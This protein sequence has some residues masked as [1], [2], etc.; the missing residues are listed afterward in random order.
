MDFKEKTTLGRTGLK[1]GRLGISS[2]YGAPAAAFEEAFER[3]CNYFNMG[4][5]IKGRSKEMMKAIRNITAKG[6]RDELV[7]A[8]YDYTHSPLIGHRH[9]MKGLRKMG[10]A[11]VDELLLGYYSSLPRKSVMDWA[12]RLKKQGLARH[13][14]VSS[15]NRKAFAAF[16]REGVIDIY[17]VRYNAVN[18]GAEK[19]VFPQ[20]PGE[21]TPGIVAYTATRWGQLLKEKKMPPGEK[22]LTASDCYRFVLSHPAVDI[23][24]TGARNLDMLRE[25]LETLEMG[26]LTADEMSRIRRIGDFIYGKKRD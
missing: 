11:Y 20:L 21:N 26:P 13:I 14:G 22:P 12:V 3:G 8:M 16:S 7:V 5:F 6:K 2:S 19:D 15:H 10:L 1:V 24:M 23:C 18:S 25:N 4:S 9:F 17:H